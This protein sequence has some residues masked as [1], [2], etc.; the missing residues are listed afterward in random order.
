MHTSHTINDSSNFDNDPDN[1]NR[2]KTFTYQG[3]GDTPVTVTGMADDL[4]STSGF[5]ITTFDASTYFNAAT[6]YDD[7]G[8][9]PDGLTISVTT[10]EVTG[11][12]TMTGTFPVVITGSDP[13][14]NN[15]TISF[16]WVVN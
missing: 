14:G 6:S 4:T 15:D 9:L 13:T 10:G 11:T 7:G 2:L 12:P 5:A 1:D 16:D 3:L 8:T